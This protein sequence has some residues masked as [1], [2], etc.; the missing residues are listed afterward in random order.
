MSSIGGKKR[1]SS[2]NGGD[3]GKKVGLFEAN[4][5]AITLASNRPTFLEKSPPPVFSL[6]FPPILLILI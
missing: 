4:V 2:G 3:F 6:F 1:E 5:I